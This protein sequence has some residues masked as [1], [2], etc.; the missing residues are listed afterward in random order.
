MDNSIYPDDG[1][2]IPDGELCPDWNSNNNKYDPNYNNDTS[3]VIFYVGRNGYVEQDQSPPL[4]TSTLSRGCLRQ[5]INENVIGLPNISNI[6]PAMQ[7]TEAA[8][9]ITDISFK[10]GY[11]WIHLYGMNLSA[12]GI[13]YVVL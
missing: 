6:Y 4:V 13:V 11:S 3:Q 9:S 2:A 1:L 7:V 10:A 12:D 8:V 5:F